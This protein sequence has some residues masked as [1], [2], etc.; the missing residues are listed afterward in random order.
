MSLKERLE[1]IE[2]SIAAPIKL[3]FQEKKSFKIAWKELLVALNERFDQVLEGEREKAYTYI[4]VMI[5]AIRQADIF[6]TTGKRPQRSSKVRDIAPR[7]EGLPRE[8]PDFNT[9]LNNLSSEQKAKA[10]QYLDCVKQFPELGNEVICFDCSSERIVGC[11]NTEDPTI[12]EPYESLREEAVGTE[13]DVPERRAIS[14][15][16]IRS[17]GF[18]LKV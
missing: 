14:K 3:T 8:K 18:R 15:E 4:E 5:S 2:S 12:H 16:E 7:E 17:T 6:A 11:I 10:E 1:H 9:I 13:G